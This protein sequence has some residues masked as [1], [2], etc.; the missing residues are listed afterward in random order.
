[1]GT[2]GHANVSGYR[3]EGQGGW[4][5]KHRGDEA[6]AY[7]VE[8][9]DLFHAV[10]QDIAYNEAELG[11]KSTLTAILGRMAAYCGKEVTFCSPA[12]DRSRRGT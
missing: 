10:R 1:V 11:A 12:A 8:H 3:I 2:R 7:Q 4:S 5:W 6:D 9:D